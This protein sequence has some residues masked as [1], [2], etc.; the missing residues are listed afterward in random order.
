M[1]IHRREFLIGLGG[2]G[3]GFG[4]GGVSHLFPLGSPEVGPDWRPG[5]ERFVPSTC[6]LCPSH[7]GILGRVADGAL[8]SI[9]GN[10]LHPVSKGGLCPKGRAG[11]Q[12]LYH[13]A[14][15]TGPVERVGPPGSRQF[16]PITW[17][18]ALD[19]IT[20]T[21]DSLRGAHRADDVV[22]LAGDLRGILEEVVERFLASYGSPHLLHE[23]YS[24]GSDEI[25]ALSQGIRPGSR[26]RWVQLDTRLSRTAVAADEWYSVHPGT[27]GLLAL[28]MAYV[29]LKEGLYDS[30]WIP[31]RAEGLE[32]WT[33]SNGN[34]VPGFRSLVMRHGRPD[35]VADQIGLPVES[36]VRLAKSFGR[37]ARPMAV[38]DQAVGWHEGGLADGLAI[39]ALN[40]LKGVLNRPGGV[41]V[42]APLPVPSLASSHPLPKPAGQQLSPG[43]NVADWA[44]QLAGQAG[45]KAEVLFLHQA[46]PVASAPNRER[47]VEALGRVPLV[48]SFSPFLDESA[49]HANLVLPDH[50]YLERWQDAPAPS[51]VPF[52]TWGVV[53]PVIPP[54]HD[55][56]AT[57]DIVLDLASR[58]GGEVA[59]SF[60]WSSIEQIVS[61]RGRALASAD[62]GGFF[63]SAFREGELR[64]LETRGWWIPH[65]LDPEKFW[66]AVRKSGGWFDPLYDEYDRS[67]ASQRPGGTVAFFPED[68]RGRIAAAEIGLAEGFLPLRGTRGEGDSGDEAVGDYP[69]K[70]LP[71]R[72]LTLA[73]GS[74]TLMPWL[75]ENIGVLSGRA[76]EV[77][78]EVHPDTARKLGVKANSRVRVASSHGSFVAWLRLFEGAQP[79]TVAVPYGLHSRIDEWGRFEVANPLVAVGNRR[80]P[81][82]GLPDW[83]STRVRIDPA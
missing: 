25:L 18:E 73:S 68:A 57:G 80:D 7:C 14:R 1:G 74:T 4:I 77:W 43:L 17:N 3:L 61:E 10:P 33:D 37:A 2:V 79:G 59:D 55:T 54:L 58:V 83:Y 44:D 11:L 82:T 35:D 36:I 62:R 12:L 63:A 45:R 23:G 48:V 22:W 21:L 24:D 15:L 39:H 56:R 19:R 46:N 40:L 6:L 42:Q 8:V 32:D 9:G 50:T 72:V 31:Y 30:E 27:Y 28:A 47:V 34:S 70:L 49:R 65:G 29:L 51:T 38:W 81:V 60:P 20:A 41:F 52:P 64:E 78:V 5:D 69:L 71:Y 26:P 16:R 13:P 53:Q 76:W 75:L 67:G 66:A